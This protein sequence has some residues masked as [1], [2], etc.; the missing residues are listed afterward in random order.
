MPPLSCDAR[1]PFPLF[2]SLPVPFPLFWNPFFGTGLLFLEEEGTRG[3]E[4]TRIYTWEEAEATPTCVE[5]VFWRRKGMG[6]NRKCF[7]HGTVVELCFRTEEGLPLSPNPF[8]LQIILSVLAAGQRRHAVTI[9]AF[10]VM[11]NHIHMLVVVEDPADIPGFARYVK[12]ELA[13]AIN[14]LLGRKKRT[15]WEEGYD[16]PSMTDPVKL[17]ERLVYF[18]TNPQRANLVDTIE[19]YPHLSS[20]GALL[21]G[22]QEY[23]CRYIPRDKIP[24]LP[25]RTLSVAEQEAVAQRLRGEG[26]EENELVIEPFAWMECFVQTAGRDPEEE[27]AEVL[28]KVREEEARC[29]RGRKV[30]V[31]G[32]STLRLRPINVAYQPK[33]YGH[34]SICLS[35]RPEYR[36]AY[37]AFYRELCAGAVKA[38]PECKEVDWYSKL[39][40]GLFA[41]GGA[42]RAN[43]LPQ[44]VPTSNTV[45]IQ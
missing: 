32:A 42:M 14:H 15:V 10:L 18:Y 20:W 45:L 35:S 11:P 38:G 2:F 40:P 29:R 16:S 36:R 25:G 24:A 1:L 9:V 3:R 28:A 12:R 23:R 8:M 13:H 31:V 39:P 26:R 41:P 34:R 6:R 19:Q 33:K 17:R 21:K 22:A 30:P 27:R 43:L 37:L 7:V 5:P 4:L 44:A